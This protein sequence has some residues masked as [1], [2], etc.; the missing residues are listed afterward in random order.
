MRPWTIS[1]WVW[2]SQ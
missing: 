1:R 2:T